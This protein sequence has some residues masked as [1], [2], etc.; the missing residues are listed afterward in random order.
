MSKPTTCHHDEG[1]TFNPAEPDLGQSLGYF[2]C[3]ACD[4]TSTDYVVEVDCEDDGDG[5]HRAHETF[6]IVWPEC[7]CAECDPNQPDDD[8]DF[9]P[10]DE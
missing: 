9:G 8:D 5:W 10:D 4:E 1:A 7:D 6:E 2:Q 3:D